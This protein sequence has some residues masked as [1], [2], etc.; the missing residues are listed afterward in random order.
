MLRYSLWFRL[1]LYWDRRLR[2]KGRPAR[3]IIGAFRLHLG[4]I[5]R[6]TTETESRNLE[7]NQGH[8]VKQ[9][10]FTD[11]TGHLLRA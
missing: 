5:V 10:H 9:D 4:A 3:F 1:F 6:F 8:Q 2:R 7:I 11:T